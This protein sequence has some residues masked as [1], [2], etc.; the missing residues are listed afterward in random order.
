MGG[1]GVNLASKSSKGSYAIKVGE[2]EISYDEFAQ[3]R[4]DF[5]ARYRKMLGDNYAQMLKTF[6]INVAQ[7]AVDSAIN[8]ALLDQFTEKMGLDASKQSIQE[9]IHSYFGGQFDA[10][11]YAAF[12]ASQGLTPAKFEEGLRKDLARQ[13][14]VDLFSDASKSSL[15][16]A[17][18][19]LERDK[20]NFSF[21][22]L[23][24]SVD[25]IKKTVA[26]P[27]SEQIS[28]Y[29]DDNLTDFQTPSKVSYN[30]T[31]LEPSDFISKVP[32]T[33]EDI[34]L[35]YTDNPSAYQNKA[36]ARFS[37]IVLK[38]PENASEEKK[39]EINK[40]AQEIKAKL[41]NGD[42]F[43]EI[44][45]SFSQDPATA[46]KGGDFGWTTKDSLPKALAEKI[47][48][49]NLGAILAPIQSESNIYIIRTDDMKEASTKPLSQVR[50]D[51]IKKIQTRDAPSVLV[52]RAQE[53][54]DTWSKSQK[55]LAEF[56]KENGFKEPKLASKM[57]KEINPE[58]GLKEL[59][60][61]VLSSQDSK[62]QIIEIGDKQV[63]VEIVD[64][65]GEGVEP[66]D[67]AKTKIIE[68]LK[69]Q[70]AKDLAK[71][72]G[73]QILES[74]KKSEYANLKDAASKNSLKI[75]EINEITRSTAK[76]PISDAQVRERIFNF[77]SAPQAP[78]EVFYVSGNY[79]LVELTNLK[80]PNLSDLDS[81]LNSIQQGLSKDLADF[82]LTSFL[83]KLKSETKIDVQPGILAE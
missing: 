36:E 51:I 2:R 6:N 26:D 57:T 3:I 19:M 24:I 13:Q 17:K 27:S 31:T 32:F 58:D 61:N 54:F 21:N 63:F 48:T 16:E 10:Q 1:F 65:I 80:K 40:S 35:E 41:D 74:I 52:L 72:K 76:G 64:L 83:S 69:T 29:Y 7:Q 50:E 28:K 44:A 46:I 53:L 60:A 33:E 75:E 5:D 37:Q 39:A 66:L 18:A 82:S 25:E 4:R 23:S 68:I 30:Y 22:T 78:T 62:Q 38:I 12:L 67:S 8:N 73:Q 71:A 11:R 47:F 79:L 45:K 70:T 14:L 56:S 59:S 49:S 9:T 55:T 20:T 43:E 81:E 15:L 34:E 77:N 42:K